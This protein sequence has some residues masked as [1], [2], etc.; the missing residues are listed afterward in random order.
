MVLELVHISLNYQHG[1]EN[2]KSA[3]HCHSQVPS[4]FLVFVER[5][6]KWILG[7]FTL[8]MTFF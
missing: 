4:G 2:I 1:M 5:N 6:G 8:R 7:K 3:K